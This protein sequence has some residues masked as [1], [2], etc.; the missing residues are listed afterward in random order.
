MADQSDVENAIATLIA[1]TLYPNGTS[2]PSV[3][4][5][6]CRVYRGYPTAPS[7]DKDLADGILNVSVNASSNAVKNVSRYPKHWVSVTPIIGS[8]NVVVTEKSAIFSGVCTVG[9]LA[10]IMVNDSIFSYA[11][12]F[13]D[14][15]ATIASNLA[16][17]LRAAGWVVDYSGEI[18]AVP[19][20]ETFTAQIV[21]GANALKEIKRQTQ[22]FTIS[23]WCPDPII[24]DLVAPIIDQTLADINFIPL[25]DGSYARLLFVGTNTKDAAA[26]ATEYQRDIIYS[27]EYPTT[28]SQISPAML[29]GTASFSANSIFAENSIT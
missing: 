3:V 15:P 9:Q 27:A 11:V 29:F 21:A 6:I 8:L 10:G 24:R 17:M 12:Q 16:A 23:L 22:E 1:N 28:L 4:S 5:M 18:L 19:T 26:N 13:N 14:S 25:A 7:L 2:A 20:A